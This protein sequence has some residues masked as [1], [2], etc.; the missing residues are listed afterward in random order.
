MLVF[1]PVVV[2]GEWYPP[3]GVTIFEVWYYFQAF[4]VGVVVFN[5]PP[6]IK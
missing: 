5:V 3:D 4:P 6:V 2:A 1:K